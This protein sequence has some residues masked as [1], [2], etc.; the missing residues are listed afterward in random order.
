M[1]VILDNAPADST[2]LPPQ[3]VVPENP[4]E[5]GLP[6]RSATVSSTGTLLNY[7]PVACTCVSQSCKPDITSIRSPIVGIMDPQGIQHSSGTFSA[8]WNQLLFTYMIDPASS[9]ANASVLLETDYWQLLYQDIV[10]PGNQTYTISHSVTDG[11]SQ[12]DT[13]SFSYTVGITIG[14]SYQGITAQISAQ[15]SQSFSRSVTVSTQE[16]VTRTLPVPEQP[17]QQIVGLY[18]LMQTFGVVPATNLVQYITQMNKGF[19]LFNM[20][21]SAGDSA[22]YPSQTYLWIMASDQ[23]GHIAAHPVLSASQAAELVKASVDIRT[24]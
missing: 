19:S 18:Q 11:L 20:H 15:L 21:F 5:T 1:S 22:I 16:T 2:T 24:P 7:V 14:G 4:V 3:P 10:P 8:K 13:S 6:Q 9:V 12:T 17:Y 23:P